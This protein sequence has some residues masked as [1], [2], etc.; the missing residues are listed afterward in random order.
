MPYI[1]KHCHCL[2]VC[3]SHRYYFSFLAHCFSKEGAQIDNM[4]MM[5]W[6]KPSNKAEAVKGDGRSPVRAASSWQV[7]EMQKTCILHLASSIQLTCSLHTEHSTAV[8]LGRSWVASRDENEPSR[9]WDGDS[10]VI[11]NLYVSNSILSAYC[12]G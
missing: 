10:K 4:M 3:T 12:G 9:S 8:L 11:R 7:L 2:H 5:V 1:P 6:R